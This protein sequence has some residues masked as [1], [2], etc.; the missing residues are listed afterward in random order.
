MGGSG[1]LG[2]MVADVL[3]RDGAV[4]VAATVR[5]RAS[6][7]AFQARAP[8]IEWA[9]FDASVPAGQRLGAMMADTVWVINCIGITKPYIHDGD[10]AETERAIRMN[11]L[12]PYELSRAAGERATVLQIMT[13]C[14]FDGAKGG[15]LEGTA[16]NVRDIYGKT[17]SLGEPLLGN[18]RSLW[19]SGI[20]PE[21][22]GFVF[23]LEWLRRQP[24]GST[25]NGYVNHRWDG[26]TSL[27]STSS[28]RSTSRA[29]SRPPTHAVLSF[30]RVC[31]GIIKSGLPLPDVQHLVA[32]DSV[33][34]AER[35]A[36]IARAYHRQ[37]LSVRPVEADSAV[38]R[39]LQTEQVTLNEA[40]W[41]AA[42]YRWP[43]SIEEMVEELA[44]FD[45]R[46]EKVQPVQA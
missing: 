29:S 5:D 16:H 23:L 8:E 38:D 21:A 3:A 7:A 24:L 44:Q 19:C 30:A 10:P 28:G 6:L 45:F 20:G 41:A 2:A 35:L 15:Y 27:T 4:R 31:L 11:S 14:V 43:P 22:R 32:G 42:G 40:M 13:D 39:T 34:K 17:K 18:V 33:S 1:M 46:F 36:C 12:F 37:D 25:V 9:P 26:V